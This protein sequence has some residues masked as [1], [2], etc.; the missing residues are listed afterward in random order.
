MPASN[1]QRLK[2]IVGILKRHQI[3]QGVDPIKF[4]KILEDLGP[5][6][7]KIGQI[8][9]TRQ[10]IFSE[11]YCKELAKL[12]DD[13]KP[14]PFDQVQ[15]ILQEAYGERLWQIYSQIEEEPLGSASVAQVHKAAL[16]DGTAVVIK[17]QRPGIYEEM[18]EDVKLIRKAAR[19]LKLSDVISS[20]VDVDMVLDEFWETTKQ[21]L[22]FTNEG[23]NGI[24][25]HE[26]YKD[27][28]YI[29][30]P[31][32]YMEY[33]SRTILVMEYIDGWE[34]DDRESLGN[35]GYKCDE[36]ARRLAENYIDQV[37]NKGFFHADPH[38]GN[39]RIRCGQI[40]FI[41]FGMMGTLTDRDR[42]LM[43]QG[44]K[45]LAAQDAVLLTDT[46][47]SLGVVRREPDYTK[48]TAAME[49]YMD[50]YCDQSLQDIDLPKMVQDMFSICHV[51]NIAL[52]KG[53][54]ML[55]R[56][57][58]TIEGTMQVLDPDI[59]IMKIVAARG[60]DY[61]DEDWGQLLK[62]LLRKS[63]AGLDHALDLPVQV[64][65]VLTMMRRGNMKVNLDLL[66]SEAPIAN[67]DRMVNR[68]VICILIASLLLSSSIIC[69]TKMQPQLLGIPLL[70]LAGFFIA[71]CMSLWL[72]VKM[73]VLHRKNKPF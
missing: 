36:I 26:Y 48:L 73:L 50:T 43:K 18:E 46:V 42:R 39:L 71:F 9:A 1:A 2:Q 17:V 16:G 69:T 27:M 45:A 63:Y 10:D 53:I 19:L 25:F 20:V 60:T 22:D 5:T 15:Q 35:A 21:E 61:L 47:L 3:Q 64:S 14:M 6:Y 34:I 72:F 11:R 8:M 58:V 12:R 54:S 37:T 7:V 23:H 30:S 67:F 31:C 52:P 41:D 49:Q 29:S 28:A 55:A 62:R 70:G 4:R 33:S 38:A 68:M 32:M 59:N 13:V 65:D 44:I 51:Y 66:G 56:S 40:V 57:L 24:R